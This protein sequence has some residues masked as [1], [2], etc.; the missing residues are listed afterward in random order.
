MD[1]YT[2]LS[3]YDQ[4]TIKKLLSDIVRYGEPKSG[5]AHHLLWLYKECLIEH[6]LKLK[7]TAQGLSLLDKLKQS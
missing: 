4:A 5:L 6:E 7:V 1:A 3:K 2:K